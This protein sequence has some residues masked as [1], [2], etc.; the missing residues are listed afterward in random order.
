MP[1]ALDGAAIRVLTTLSIVGIA[2]VGAPPTWAQA[3][4]P[5][6]PVRLVIPFAPGGQTDIMGRRIA[7]KATPLLGQQVIPDNRSGAGGT[8]GSNEVARSKPDGYTVLVATSSTHA[9]NPT[10]MPKIPYDAVKDF[11]PVAILGTVPM[12]IVV[13]PSIPARNLAE[14]VSLAKTRPGQFAYGSTGIGGINHLG[15]ELFKLQ[16]GKL[17]ITHVP[18]KS[19]GLALQDLMGG[20]MPITISTVSSAMNAHRDKRVRILAVASEKRTEAAPDIPTAIE[21]GVPGMIAYT[22]NAILL[23]AGT[24]TP[25]IERWHQTVQSIM[26]DAAFVKDLVNL[27]VEP[28]RDSN[29]K[30]AATFISGEIARWAPIIR[31]AMP[32]R[33]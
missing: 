28:I 31:T 21:A 13:H 12:S 11:A 2:A 22:F 24:P 5:E 27:G 9:I 16:A 20:H 17:D 29:P 8:I 25:V 26:A 23:P 10:A 18:Y 7:A 6:R 4:Y 14:L 19:S 3:K 15:G 1:E 30:H 33:N 32:A